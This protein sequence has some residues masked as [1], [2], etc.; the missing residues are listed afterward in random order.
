MLSAISRTAKHPLFAQ[1]AISLGLT[2][3]ALL[4]LV[5]VLLSVPGPIKGLYWFSVA[6][7]DGMTQTS[8]CT[9]APLSDQPYLSSMINVGQA[10][11]VRIMLPLACYWEIVV[12]VCWVVLSITSSM[13]Y[14]IR[15]LDSI[16][17]HLRFAVV[18]SCV[19]CVS[20]FGNVLCWMAFGLG[21]TAYLSVQ[22]GGAQ[23]KSGHAMETTA[24]A[25][26]ISLISLF[27]AGW[28]LHLRMSEAQSH[29]KEE[30]VMVR[31]RS[32]ALSAAHAAVGAGDGSA[33]SE[34][35]GSVEKLRWSNA[36]EYSSTNGSVSGRR[37]STAKDLH[38]TVDDERLES[39]LEEARRNSRDQVAMIRRE[40]MISPHDSPYAAAAAASNH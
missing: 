20:L 39:S 1:P 30:A 28:G 11:T 14:Q 12:L 33:D 10:L 6:G 19:L 29:W 35:S 3:L 4:L 32:M 23:P 13:G 31:R 8:N 22:D 40:S 7:Q 18:E 38:M 9:Y 15:D 24:V 5:L 26:M 25:A 34:G 17:R 16:T 37:S 2:G 36:P 21:R 27:T